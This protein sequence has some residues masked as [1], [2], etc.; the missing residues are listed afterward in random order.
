MVPPR[1]A[2]AASWA[3]P[4]V[5]EDD[6]NTYFFAFWAH[7]PEMQRLIA[8]KAPI[9]IASAL[10]LGM[11]RQDLCMIRSPRD[12]YLAMRRGS[13]IQR[14]VPRVSVIEVA[15]HG[16]RRA[17]GWES[18]VARA[19]GGAL[20]RPPAASAT[21]ASNFGPRWRGRRSTWR[22]RDLA[23]DCLSWFYCQGHRC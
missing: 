10:R 13:G 18:G 6:T 8:A 17:D 14:T 11:N 12:G 5:P 4:H 16:G 9:A 3:R 22:P 23:L 19:H 20:T 15:T 2:M 21:G 1:V 7:A